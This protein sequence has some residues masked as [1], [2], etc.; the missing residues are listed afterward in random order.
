MF[1]DDS[2][3]EA[4]KPGEPEESSL[5]LKSSDDESLIDSQRRQLKEE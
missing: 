3:L 5:L 4:E 1:D 2:R